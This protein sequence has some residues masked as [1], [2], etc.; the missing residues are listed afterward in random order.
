M[1]NSSVFLVFLMFLV[2]VFTGIL[3]TMLIIEC[4]AEKGTFTINRPDEEEEV[5]TIKV[6][7]ANTPELLVTRY[8]ILTR[9]LDSKTSQK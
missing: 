4:S 5:C 9:E 1:M 7:I 6:S 8:I 3:V 2:G